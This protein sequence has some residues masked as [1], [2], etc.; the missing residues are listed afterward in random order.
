MMQ[1][2]FYFTQMPSFNSLI[3]SRKICM[4]RKIICCGC[5]V[6]LHSTVKINVP[7]F[8]PMVTRGSLG[9][10]LRFLGVR[11]DSANLTHSL[12]D[13]Q[14]RGMQTCNSSSNTSW[15]QDAIVCNGNATHSKSKW[16]KCSASTNNDH[17]HPKNP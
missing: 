10:I 12:H 5:I 15:W 9:L 3:F 7:S 17:K 2:C 14:F 4:V 6:S 8:S 16:T 1:F 13:V 11:S